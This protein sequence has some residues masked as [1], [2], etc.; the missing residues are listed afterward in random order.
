MQRPRKH[1]RMK[2]IVNIL[3]C[4]WLLLLTL[5]VAC[6]DFEEIVVNMQG[7][8]EVE[9]TIRTN[10]PGLGGSTRT[11][12]TENITNITALAFD[13]DKKL[14]KVA[15]EDVTTSPSANPSISG[16]YTVKVPVRT[17][18]IHFI[19]KNDGEFDTFS[20][21][22][23]YGKGED[24]LLKDL[25][26]TELHY[27][28]KLDFDDA[29]ALKAGGD[30]T[31]IRNMAKLV[32][33]TSSNDD[34]IAGLLNHNVKGTIV[35]YKD[36]VLGYQTLTNHDLPTNFEIANDGEGNLGK[37]HY[38]FEEF[39]DIIGE[40]TDLV[41]AICNIGGKFYK[42]AFK[43][44]DSYYYIIRNQV[45][46]I[47]IAGTLDDKLGRETY[48]DAVQNGSPINDTTKEQVHIT[49]EPDGETTFPITDTEVSMY[50]GETGKVKV[51]IPEGI[52]ELQIGYKTE[53][54]DEDGLIANVID[55]DVIT[56]TNTE[57]KDDIYIKTYDVT[58]IREFEL[59]IDLN[60][61]V[62][63]AIDGLEIQFIGSG[64]L[65]Q[66]NDKLIVDVLKRDDITLSKTAVEIPK[67]AGSEFTVSV[68]MPSFDNFD[69]DF[70]LQVTDVDNKFTIAP[71]SQD[72]IYSVAEGSQTTFTF[73]LNADG[74]VGDVYTINFVATSDFHRLTGTTTVTLIDDAVP[75]PDQDVYEIWVGDGSAWTGTTNSV[76]FFGYT[77]TSFNTGTSSNLENTFYDPSA[78]NHKSQAMVMGSDDSFTFTIP[79]GSNRWLT[80]LV[81]SDGSGNTPSIQLSNGTWATASSSDAVVPDTY[82]FGNGEINTAGRLIRYEL[83]PGTYT[84]KGSDAAYLLYY[85]RVTKTKPTMT[86]IAQP[87]LTDYDL[88]WSGG[89]YANTEGKG[90]LK[91]SDEKHIVDEDNLTHTVSLKDENSL[92]SSINLSTSTLSGIDLE[93]ETTRVTFTNENENNYSTSETTQNFN[94]VADSYQLTTYNAGVYTLSGTIDNPTYKYSAFYDKLQLKYVEYEVKNPIKPGLYNSMNGNV[95]TPVDGFTNLD[96]AWAI[97]FLMP[98]V[99]PASSDDLM[100]NYRAYT[101][102]INIPNWTMS[103]DISSGLGVIEGENGNY[104]LGTQTDSNNNNEM[105]HPREGWTYKIAMASI[106]DDEIVPSLTGDKASDTDHYFTYKGTIA[107][108]VS[109]PTPYTETALN[110]TLD[111][112]TENNVDFSNLTFGETKF[113]LKATIPS[114]IPAGRQIMLDLATSDGRGGI[115]E[116]QSWNQDDSKGMSYHFNENE[117]VDGLTITTTADQTEYLMCWKYVR[118]NENN[119]NDVS[120]TYTVSSDKHK[121]D[122]E[123]TATITIKGNSQAVDNPLDLN[124]DFYALNTSGQ[125]VDNGVNGSYTDL[126]LNSSRFVLEITID[127]ADATKY[128][129]QTVY[130][131]GDF[132][133]TAAG[134][135]ENGWAI[136]WGNS[137]TDGAISYYGNNNNG[138][139]LQFQIDGN[140]TYKIEWVFKTGGNYN[141]GQIGFDY[142]ISAHTDT[143]TTYNLKGDTQATIAFTNEPTNTEPDI[144]DGTTIWTGSQQW[145][146]WS[147]DG[148]QPNYLAINYFLPEGTE[149]TLNVTSANGG[150]V[151]MHDCTLA[152]LRLASSDVTY[153]DQGDDYFNVSSGNTSP[154]FIVP[155][156]GVNGLR[157]NGSN[158]TITSVVVKYPNVTGEIFSRDFNDNN[159]IN[160]WG[161]EGHVA[162][163]A[164]DGVLVLTNNNSGFAQAAVDMGYVPGSYTL[165]YRIQG[166]VNGSIKQNFQHYYSPKNAD[167]S[168]GNDVYDEDINNPKDQ[169]TQFATE[170]REVKVDITISKGANRLLFDYSNFTGT[171]YIDDLKLVKNN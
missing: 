48:T 22:A 49:F 160:G 124:L 36:G 150:A 118:S 109:I 70:N 122:G 137:R 47:K 38:M 86:D 142:K 55:G 114:G 162:P 50:L 115:N 1:K 112:Y 23:D 138:S 52:T 5:V 31:L 40:T 25:T 82:N 19:A 21:E 171:I 79:E 15:I 107:K 98:S 102:G 169:A 140:K 32:L 2:R 64:E 9:L 96:E 139:G 134:A 73:T 18:R 152:S 6:S 155:S 45:Y 61:S 110:I 157:I 133:T 141:G 165:S 158:V 7:E 129:G 117:V 113:Y 128:N 35:P 57:T 148:Y 80:M 26:T 12:P 59:S 17:R 41:Y 10:V 166:T 145:G 147:A 121:L 89:Q 164:Q 149:I 126:L 77:G 127:D 54:F 153:P 94:N 87:E 143:P 27:W 16:T 103:T 44:G 81:A 159:A 14:I 39:N 156:G 56:A 69:G 151:E 11:A 65:K 167:G 62:T 76:D 125:K 3:S 135:A 123:N 20:T 132:E 120:I 93:V 4:L 74:S 34:Y 163:T 37:V 8:E 30:V 75:V 84:L 100:S 29:T 33:E 144:T 101:I 78:D 13:S 136:H 88:A 168:N 58:N 90:Y 99:V 95:L 60:E 43:S 106:A 130:L 53:F 24:E 85:M 28:G 146:D 131:A 154:K 111:F 83:E 105:I 161:G 51:I 67:S 72:G 46:T 42:I 104:T 97:G 91:I 68:T 71:E 108:K 170:W 66:S 116:W 119:T 63:E 92:K